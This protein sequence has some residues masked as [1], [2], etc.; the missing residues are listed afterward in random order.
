[1]RFFRVRNISAQRITLHPRFERPKK[2]TQPRWAPIQLKPGQSSDPIP[3]GAL[4]GSKGWHE[5]RMHRKVEL[6]AVAA[7]TGFVAIEVVRNEKMRLPIKVHLPKKKIVKH[8]LVITPSQPRTV[9]LKSI[10]DGAALRNLAKQRKIRFTQVPYIAPSRRHGWYGS[11]G[12]EAVDVCWDCGGPI[13][14]RGSPP[15][16]IHI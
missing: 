13:V 8:E 6:I 9:H 1:M 16:P 10:D 5:F 4:I 2:R 14:F 12:D 11:Y 15:T 7:F 3:E